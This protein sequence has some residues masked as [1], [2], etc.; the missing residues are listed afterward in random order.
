MRY[1]L[2]LLLFFS[3]FGLS[4]ENIDPDILKSL[5]ESELQE[6]LND[7][8]ESQDQNNAELVVTDSLTEDSEEF[9]DD[10]NEI[11]LDKELKKFGYDFFSKIPTTITPT[12]DLPVPNDYKISLNDEFK[13]LLS[14][15]IDKELVLRVNLD[16]AILFP[17]VGLIQIV[18]DD[19]DTAKQKIINRVQKAYVGVGVNISLSSLSAKKINIVGAVSIPGS[20]LV[21]PFTT[22]TSALAYAGGIEEYGSLRTI[23]VMKS[24]GDS[25]VFDLYELLISG[26]RTNDALL[27]AGD[28]I[29][30]QGT[31]NFI[32]IF[33]EVIRPAVYEYNQ[34]DSLNKLISLALGVNKLANLNTVGVV[35]WDSDNFSFKTKILNINEKFEF[36]N[37]L[38]VEVFKTGANDAKD[39]RVRG[40]IKNP[41]YYRISEFDKLSQIVENIAF[42][43]EIFPFV[44]SL[45]QYNPKK[46]S[47]DLILFSL[48][49]KSTYQNITLY[50]GAKINFLSTSDFNFL[51]EVEETES[52]ETESEET[53]RVE[54]TQGIEEI[55]GESISNEMEEY[56]LRINFKGEQSLFPVYGKFSI[57]SV[58]NFLG[59]KLDD[60]GL[61]N[62]SYSSPSNDFTEYGDYKSMSFD[63]EKFHTLTIQERND[64]LVDVQIS[65]EVFFPGSYKVGPK[66]TLS[67]LVTIA[68]GM[69]SSASDGG[70]ILKRESVRQSQLEAVESAK[71]D[72]NEY[73]LS[74][75]RLGNEVSEQF[76]SLLQVQINEENLGRIGGNFQTNSTNYNNF[77]LVNGDTIFIPKQRE[78]V[79][80]LG[81]VLNA[82]TV[83]YSNNLTMTDYIQ[84]AGGFKKSASKSEIYIIRENGLVEKGDT[85]LFTGSSYLIMPGDTIIVP[86]ELQSVND[87]VPIIASITSILSNTAF[88]AASI[89][90]I[91]D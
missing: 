2:T 51:N 76:I 66:T 78:T 37:A 45:E 83:V 20:Y 24:N 84:L 44:A 22:I 49:D 86:R 46:F 29:L 63:A 91:N 60:Q 14:G 1:S 87:I 4:Q 54:I 52:E 71:R 15:G 58:I 64:E 36:D 82:N 81:E 17:E 28:T 41:G 73:V 69:R 50:P 43:S 47:K 42:T 67:E 62:V 30:V 79:A 16:G 33:G 89:N 53:E 77:T 90:A 72:L 48:A 74:Q 3:F 68:G 18:G 85:N 35:Y 6:I 11:N 39:V 21:N 56:A 75:I 10:E 31:D 19:F 13:I 70:L 34:E 32:E 27:D 5:P 12:A 55:L 57:K 23:K 25:Y 65:G 26:D 59:L 40:P 88:L 8:N 7:I 9:L 38:S 80:I 61:E